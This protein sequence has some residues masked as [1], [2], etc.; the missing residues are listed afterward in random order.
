MLRACVLDIV[1][2]GKAVPD[3]AVFVKSG[4]ANR[5][6]RDKYGIVSVVD[7]EE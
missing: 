7:L 2:R 5:A 3:P 4:F 6:Q 1:M